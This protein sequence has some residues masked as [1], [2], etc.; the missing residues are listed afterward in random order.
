[1]KTHAIALFCLILAGCNYPIAPPPESVQTAIVQTQRIPPT[2]T[3]AAQFM[4]NPLPT[5]PVTATVPPTWETPEVVANS[6]IATQIAQPRPIFEYASVYGLAH[7]ENGQFLITLEIPGT[8]SGDY[9]AMLGGESFR[10]QI[11]AEFPNRLYCNG[12]TSFAGQMATLQLQDQK[13]GTV[14]FETEIGIPPSPFAAG[15]TNLTEKSKG[16]GHSD[17]D[18]PTPSEEAYPGP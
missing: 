5:P 4:E 9:Q 7:L 13:E 12:L 1:M 15:P 10:C 17:Q 16:N 8:L 18:T 3:F 14:V 6:D 2:Q 11:L